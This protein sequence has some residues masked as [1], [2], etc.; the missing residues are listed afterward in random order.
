[1]PISHFCPKAPTWSLDWSLIDATYE[2]V[3]AMR[4]VEQSPLFHGEGDVWIHTRMVCQE[5]VALKEWLE[6]PRER[7]EMLFTAALLHDVAKPVCTRKDSDGKWTSKGH[8]RRGASM[9][10]EILWRMGCPRKLREQVCNLVLNHQLPF[11][12]LER[13]D[14]ERKAVE[15]AETTCWADLCLLTEADIRGRE[16]LD[17]EELLDRVFMTREWTVE[18]GCFEGP[19]D[20]PSDHS[21]F[22]WCRDSKRYIGAKAWDDTRSKVTLLSGVPGSGKDTWLKTHRPELPVVS[23]DNIRREFGVS[24][25]GNQGRVIQEARERARVFLRAG[26]SFAWN[27]TNVTRQLRKKSINLFA[28]YNARIEIVSL[29]VGAET[30]SVRNQ[31]REHPVP[32][33]IIEKLISKWEP[34]DTTEA[35]QIIYVEQ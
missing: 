11:F 33:H 3:E 1:M 25:L 26:Q 29:E 23:L 16:C 5:M 4:G 9:A 28:D 35:H 19:F 30:L 31:T 7:Q 27:A 21:R 15:V 14:G 13:D 8:S 20:F 32:M 12:I 17:K 2:W 18:L 34:P 24:P 10:R 6:S 22:L